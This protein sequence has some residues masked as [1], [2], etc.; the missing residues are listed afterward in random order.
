MRHISP[1]KT[2]KISSFQNGIVQ[3][4]QKPSDTFY[5]PSYKKLNLT[6]EKRKNILYNKDNACARTP[7]QPKGL[8]FLRAGCV[9]RQIKRKGTTG[10]HH[11]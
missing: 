11:G 8:S 7:L 10:I 2:R 5:I 4:E 9:S 6:L 3:T 1:R